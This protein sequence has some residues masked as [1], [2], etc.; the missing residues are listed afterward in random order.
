MLSIS[1][2]AFNVDPLFH[3]TS[4]QFDEGGAGGLL[5]NNLSVYR[6]CEIVFD[7]HEVPEKVMKSEAAAAASNAQTTPIDLSFMKGKARMK[8]WAP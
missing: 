4:A 1:A 6:G 8:G 3:Q 7:S 5:L 2:V